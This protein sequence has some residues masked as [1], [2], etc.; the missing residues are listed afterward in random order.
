ML[1]QSRA[2]LLRP[3]LRS[4]GHPLSLFTLPPCGWQQG[5]GAAGAGTV[6]ALMDHQGRAEAKGFA[7]IGAHV[8]LLGAALSVGALVPVAVG[9]AAKAL[10]AVGAGEGLLPS[11][12]EPVPVVVGAPGEAFPTEPALVRRFSSS[13]HRWLCLTTGYVGMATAAGCPHPRWCPGLHEA[14]A[15]LSQAALAAMW[16]GRPRPFS[17]APCLKPRPPFRNRAAPL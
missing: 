17:L 12:R 3:E 2:G 5:Q 7:A 8:A 1:L 13:R 10:P 9:A 14:G 11:V 15:I 6:Q 4:C 16:E